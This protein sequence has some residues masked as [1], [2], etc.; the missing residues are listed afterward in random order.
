[1]G[2]VAVAVANAPPYP[3]ACAVLLF[4]QA[5]TK[6][7]HIHTFRG[8]TRVDVFL[9]AFQQYEVRRAIQTREIS[10]RYA[11]SGGGILHH[12]SGGGYK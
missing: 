1:V 5:L 8:A 4:L 7:H 6:L 10:G 9:S 11:A 2:T 12:F 3:R